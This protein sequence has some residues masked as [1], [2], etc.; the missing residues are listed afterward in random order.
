[1]TSSHPAPT[2]SFVPFTILGG[3]SIGTPKNQKFRRLTQAPYK[4]TSEFRKECM[5][6][7]V[8]KYMKEDV[9]RRAAFLFLPFFLAFPQRTPR[10]PRPAAYDTS[11]PEFIFIHVR[12][13]A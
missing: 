7:R 12:Q 6:M 1:M 13:R 11:G 2:G 8:A 4:A 10:N 3:R 9:G 5:I